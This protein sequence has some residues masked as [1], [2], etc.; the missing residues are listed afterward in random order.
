MRRMFEAIG[1]KQQFLWTAGLVTVPLAQTACSVVVFSQL[2]L[3]PLVRLFL[4]YLIPAFITLRSGLALLGYVH[5]AHS[6]MRLQDSTAYWMCR[7]AATISK[8]ETFILGCCVIPAKWCFG[9]SYILFLG[10]VSTFSR[11]Y[12]AH[13]YLEGKSSSA[14]QVVASLAASTT[15]GTDTEGAAAGAIESLASVPHAQERIWNIT[16]QTATYT[17]TQHDMP[18][19]PEQTP[20]PTPPPTPTYTGVTS[21]YTSSPVHQT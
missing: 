16:V 10:T 21:A 12:I 15:H 9:P 18:L 2:N 6:T 13:R 1:R 5:L 20:P 11:G 8:S 7:K 3:H 17:A 14:L 4:V 19:T